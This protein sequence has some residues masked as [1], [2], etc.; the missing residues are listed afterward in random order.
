MNFYAPNVFLVRF[1][2]TVNFGNQAC[3]LDMS[4]VILIFTCQLRRII[5]QTFFGT[6]E[7]SSS[8]VSPCEHVKVL[9]VS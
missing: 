2:L 9:Q 5:G 8:F 4:R 3:R 7:R 6:C 1:V